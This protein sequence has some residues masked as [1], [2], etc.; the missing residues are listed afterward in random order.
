M[1]NISSFPKS[2]T[3]NVSQNRSIFHG[4]G[5]QN[6]YTCEF[7]SKSRLT[8]LFYFSVFPYFS[9]WFSATNVV[10]SSREIQCDVRGDC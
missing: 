2:K 5:P 1:V 4:T 8:P 10:R 7:V 6:D 3:S 9:V